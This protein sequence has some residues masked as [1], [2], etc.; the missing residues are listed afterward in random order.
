MEWYLKVLKQYADFSGRARRTEF[1][2]FYLFN[3]LIMLG[4]WMVCAISFAITQSWV[5]F[6]I[7]GI[8]FFLYYLATLIPMLAVTV[9][10]LHDT[11]NSGFMYFV[12]FIPFVGGIWLIILLCTDGMQGY[13]NYG[14]DPKSD[15]FE[16]MIDSLPQ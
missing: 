3:M 7:F 10:R 1:W 5:A 6:A 8:L 9:R 4:L 13:N 16:E 15:T 11:G 14:S 2:M 12:S